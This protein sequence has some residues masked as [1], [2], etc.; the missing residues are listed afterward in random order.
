MNFAIIFSILGAVLLF[1]AFFI[2]LPCIVSLIYHESVG[3]D[4]LIVAVICLVLGLLL[5]LIKPKKKIFY[6]KEGFVTVALSWIIMS[7]MGALP[8]V[9]SGEI[10]GEDEIK[11]FEYYSI[12]KI[13]VVK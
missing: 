7:I 12:N 1:E 6:A 4:Y 9:V 11:L 10:I 8:F 3:I 13:D 5:R 2:T